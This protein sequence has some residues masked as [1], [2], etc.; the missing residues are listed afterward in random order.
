MNI[1]M[2]LVILIVLNTATALG[3]VHNQYQKRVIGIELTRMAAEKDQLIDKWSQLLVEYA[4]WSANSRIEKI[5][6]EKLGMKHEY[7][8][9]VFLRM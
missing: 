3:V 7:K 4:S 1:V 9:Y 2:L 6:V 5:A 8:D